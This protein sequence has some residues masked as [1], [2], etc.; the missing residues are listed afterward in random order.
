MSQSNSNSL[1]RKNQL[2]EFEIVDE[3]YEFIKQ[4]YKFKQLIQPYRNNEFIPVSIILQIIQLL[5]PSSEVLHH[6]SREH[7]VIKN[8]IKDLL[9]APIINWGYNRPPDLV[10]C[11]DIA[12]YMYNSRQPI[13]TMF[14]LNFNNIE[15]TFEIIDGIHRY[16]SLKIIQTE[17]KKPLDLLCP[18]DYGNNNDAQWIMEQYVLVNLRFNTPLGSLIEVFRSLNKSN[19]V[20]ELYIRDTAKEKRT[21]IQNIANSWQIKYK[22][23]FSPN[24]KP[25][26]PNVNR[27]RFIELLDYVYD[28]YK[29]CEENKQMLERLLDNTNQN[30]KRN[31]PKKLTPK[32]IEKCQSSDCY[33]FLYSLERLE[34]II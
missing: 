9:N 21:I 18:G 6:F 29:I 23:H 31:L 26:K 17:N 22:E 7:L 32:C 1:T 14:Y 30:I 25:N 19:P 10:R 15:Q 27:D 8:K 20:P 5:L 11:N 12:K 2:I 34:K 4:E 24:S 13:D 3:P 28:K 33:L 16:T